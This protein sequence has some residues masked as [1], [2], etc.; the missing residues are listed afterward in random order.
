[1]GK[2]FSRQSVV[3][4]IRKIADEAKQKY[5]CSVETSDG[6]QKVTDL[7]LLLQDIVSTNPV[8]TTVKCYGAFVKVKSDGC[9]LS[10]DSNYQYGIITPFLANFDM[11]YN[12][13]TDNYELRL[14][15]LPWTGATNGNGA[16][17]IEDIVAILYAVNLARRQHGLLASYARVENYDFPIHL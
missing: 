14:W 16:R 3:K 1:M 8:G 6:W 10:V 5:Q 17:Y 11:D 9:T 4:E 15:P 2:L 13:A 12:E 7:H